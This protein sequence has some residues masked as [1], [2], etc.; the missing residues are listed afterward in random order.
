M[1]EQKLPEVD[2]IDIGEIDLGDLDA[3]TS[4]LQEVLE[5]QAEPLAIDAEA[6]DAAFE[7][8]LK[9]EATAIEAVTEA[10]L[11]FRRRRAAE[12]EKSQAV[13]DSDYYFTVVLD[14]RE[15]AIALLNGLGLDGPQTFVDGR[16]LAAT[17]GIELPPRPA[18]PGPFRIDSQLAHMAQEID[19]GADGS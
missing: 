5:P 9:P 8:T 15:Q 1:S 12:K 17:L 6:D 7:A 13:Y 19:D 16:A 4:D 10:Q 3:L 14:S 11:A 2:D 18:L